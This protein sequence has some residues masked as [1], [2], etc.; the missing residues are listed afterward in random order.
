M[1]DEV[2]I[3][4]IESD[5]GH[6]QVTEAG[7]GPLVIMLHGF[8]ELAYSWRHQIRPVAEAGWK[9]IAPDQRGYGASSVP[10]SIDDYT[11]H[12]LVGDVMA[13]ADDLGEERF[14]LVGH[15]WGSMVA[16]QCALSR[17]DR[18]A[19]LM[20]LSVPILPPLDRSVLEIVDRQR[21]G[22][23]H[24]MRYFQE[25]G[26]AE[27]ELDGDPMGFLRRLWWSSSGDWPDAL[28][29]PDRADRTTFFDDD[30]HVPRG[31]PPWCEVGDMEA[32]A[33]AFIA[34]GF[35]GPLGWYRNL[36]RNWELTRPWRN[37]PIS[38][39]C[40]FVGGLADAV[41][42]GGAPG[43]PGRGVELMRSMCDLRQETLLD[44]IGHWVQQEAPD[45]VTSA[46]LAFLDDLGR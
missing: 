22:G 19:G 12:Q 29:R 44:G 38:V 13:I 26:L 7:D 6:L 17:P 21:N 4:R 20:S 5:A 23:F 11:I 32:S 46:I 30:L 18:V 36:Q 24:Y 37:T 25:P 34:N 3:R 39:P 9:V 40:A 35:S 42:H 27:A 45:A 2:T 14:V 10:A 15:D 8:P 28:P 33:R 1:P 31:L 41:V 43:R 16:T